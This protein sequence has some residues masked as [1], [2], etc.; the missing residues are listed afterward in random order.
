MQID[1]SP[2][3]THSTNTKKPFSRFQSVPHPGVAPMFQPRMRFLRGVSFFLGVVI[4]VYVWHIFMPRIPFLRR[5]SEQTT[6]QRWVIIARRFR[7]LA[8]S[9]GGMQIKF[10]QFLSSRADIIPDLVRREL[11][12]LQDEVPPAPAEHVLDLIM[13]EHGMPP[14]KLFRHFD[15]ECVAAA[16]L[17]Q[18]HYAILHDGNEV[19][20]KVQRPHIEQ[21]IDVD[22]QAVAWVLRLIKDHYVVRRRA[23][24]MAL[25]EEFGRVLRR[26]LD[27]VQEAQNADLFRAHFAGIPGIYVPYPIPEMTTRRVL[28]MERVGGIKIS[29]RQALDEAGI[30][31]YELADRLN[32]TYL[33]QL[34]LDGFFHADP[35]PGNF[36]VRPEHEISIISNNGVTPPSETSMPWVDNVESAGTPF[37]L[38]FLDFGMV[39]YL[40]PETMSIVRSGVLGLAVND[41]ERIVDALYELKMFLPG[42]DRRTIVQAIEIMMRHSYNRSVRELNNMDVE[43]IFDETRD[44][45]YDLP[46]QIPQDLLYMGRAISMVAGLA[47]EIYPDINLFDSLR[48]FARRMLAQEQQEGDWVDR[49]RKELVELSQILLALPRQMDSYYKSAN[50]GELQMRTDFGRLERM[51]RRVERST[52]RLTGGMVASGLFLGG[53]QLYRQGKE[54]E[55]Q[56]VWWAAA[57]ALLWS[58]W[59]RGDNR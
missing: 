51:I 34:F 25:H 15:H 44:L 6:M 43:Q 32:Q 8:I 22:L 57:L 23:D 5:Y 42:S 21:I 36:F 28:V 1:T 3:N 38:I 13:K 48:P 30:D 31:R 54:K 41:A 10:G 45:V 4:H 7:K 53:V 2:T 39:S 20:V 58:N 40:P 29:D 56:R 27:Y 26:E 11:A 37:T 47:T 9:M 52:D 35:H 12:G 49:T 17:G 24:V 55:A 33:K 14:D 18:V 50:R 16:S 59:P 19:A 46:F